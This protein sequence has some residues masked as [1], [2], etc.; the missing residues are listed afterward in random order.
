MDE[1]VKIFISSRQKE[2][3][4][5]RAWA[6]EA[7]EET[8]HDLS[9][10]SKAILVEHKAAPPSTTIH[11][12]CLE[13]L[14][15]CKVIICIYYKTISPI[16]ENEFCWANERGIP[17]FIFRKK[18][19]KGEKA[20]EDLESFLREEVRPASGEPTGPYGIY[21]YKTFTGEDIKSEIKASLKKYYPTWFN[22]K[23]IPEKYLPSA[24]ESGESERLDRISN[25]YVKPSCYSGAKEKLKKN[26]LLIITGPAHLGKT[27][28]AFYLADSFRKDNIARR[29]IIFPTD[30]DF[31]DI[32]GLRHSVIVFDDPFGSVSYQPG[33][34]GDISDKLSQL[35]LKNYVIVTSRREVLNEALKYQ[36]LGERKREDFVTEMVQ[37]DYT[38]K[39]FEEILQ[40][41]LDFYKANDGIITLTNRHK[42]EI[43]WALKFP[44]NYE[45]LVAVELIKVINK[46]KDFRQ[47]IK[48]AKEIER[49]V[50]NWFE[51][52]YSKDKEV[53][54]FLLTLALC[55]EMKEE[56]F[57][58]IH[59]KAIRRLNTERN[60]GLPFPGNLSRLR[61]DTAS[62]VSQSGLLRLE[63]PSYEEGI[64]DHI[65]DS[66]PEDTIVILKEMARQKKIYLVRL[67]AAQG[68]AR[69]GELLPESVMPSLKD[70]A[71]DNVPGP[72]RVWAGEAL[73]RIGKT[74]PKIVIPS[75]KS[76][77]NKVPYVVANA[78]RNIGSTHLKQTLPVFSKL[79]GNKALD[80]EWLVTNVLEEIVR[81]CPNDVLDVLPSFASDRNSN[82]RWWA[83]W[84]VEELGKTNPN[85]TLPVLEKLIRDKNP[86]V[87]LRANEA[88]A[89]VTK[90]CPKETLLVLEKLFGNKNHTERK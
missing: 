70:L 82:M 10:D 66:Y 4:Q 57:I 38:D 41:H 62:Y 88:L 47:A 15:A 25:V 90:A 6:K 17:T 75:L 3:E 21:V 36:K 35:A 24:I 18:L 50:G 49:A 34:T 73:G 55:G 78:L 64:M 61:K 68:I 42:R 9:K 67:R 20:D 71:C 12:Q 16:V 63:H 40:K 79:A 54:Y 30:G 32:A 31:S 27:S 14:K 77:A 76:L 2:L 45:R 22:F 81:D 48:D 83:A 39:D 80:L 37:E 56:D 52:W 1:A 74:H 8:G 7:V 59:Q 51:G 46:E 85:A 29:F 43:L 44:H 87:R 69:V 28:I 72:V 23:P 11:T 65:R 19:Q 26:R 33:L 84:I 13:E 89:V 60:L 53:F 58:R 5:E 86:L